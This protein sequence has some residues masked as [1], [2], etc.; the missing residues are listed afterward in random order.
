MKTDWQVSHDENGGK[1]TVVCNMTD[2]A[3]DKEALVIRVSGRRHA[4]FAELL[5]SL[6]QSGSVS[7]HQV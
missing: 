7:S 5:A 2:D 4:R 3:D 1:T 6:L